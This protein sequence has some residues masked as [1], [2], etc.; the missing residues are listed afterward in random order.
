M[1]VFYWAAAVAAVILL[2][3]AR[4][5]GAQESAAA[6]RARAAES[7]YNL[8]YEQAEALYA[9]ALAVA[10]DD[11]PAHRGLATAEWLRIMVSRGMVTVDEF[12]GGRAR[13][14]L[15]LPPPPPQ[16]AARFHEHAARA[17]QL[18]ERAVK[19]HPGDAEAQFQYG[20]SV[21]LLASYGATVEGRVLGAFRSAKNAYDAHERVLALDPRRRDAGL[22]VG[23]YRYLVSTLSLPGRWL[24]YLAGFGGG[25]DIG[26]RM[27]EDAARYPSESQREAELAL[28]LLYNRE[29]RYDEALRVLAAL[30]QAF[31]RNRLFW[32]ESGA[33]ALRAGRAAEAEALL[34]EGLART[35]ADP[36]PRAYGELA[37]WRLK[38]GTA[39]VAERRLTDARASLTQA[40]DGDAR[41]WVRARTHLELG[42]LADL[43][44]RRGDAVREYRQAARLAASGRDDATAGDA[45]RLLNRP[46]R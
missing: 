26:L 33:T 17:L 27:I 6:L 37:L 20:A 42:K 9:R 25:H 16:V 46:F 35:K 22:V 40:L 36:R 12:L 10:P 43:E 2:V 18:S 5:T 39:R 24:A 29:R 31:P 30:R 15:D 41:D 14:T 45:S 7:Y 34:A 23:T 13:Q 1:K 11:V 44:G 21:G 4:A 32:L 19:A 8:D 28:V 38:L 3:A